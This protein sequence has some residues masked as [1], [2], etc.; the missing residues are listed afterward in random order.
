M[1]FFLTLL[2]VILVAGCA[3][4]PHTPEI[5]PSSDATAEPSDTSQA[6]MPPATATPPPGGDLHSNFL[7]FS[8]GIP[9]QVG[10]AIVSGPSSSWSFGEGTAATA[11]ST[12]KVPLAIAALRASPGQATQFVAPAIRQSNN[13][14]AETLWAI[15]GPPEEAASAVQEILR[16]G[17]DASTT[18]ES[19]RTRP[20][21]TAFGQTQ[22]PLSAEATFAWHLPCL[23]NNGPVFSDMRQIANDQLWGLADNADVAAKGGWGPGISGGY[24]VRQLASMST[25]SGTLG[26]ALAAEPSDGTFASGVEAINRLAQWVRDHR[27]SFPATAC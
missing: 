6:P 2:V 17:G 5:A 1:R 26:V 23:A 4:T 11:W 9:A 12:I 18:V 19:E 13:A 7:E 14:A 20:G 16:E 25:P 15:L 21:F 22:W 8:S 24:L 10:V 27:D 3:K